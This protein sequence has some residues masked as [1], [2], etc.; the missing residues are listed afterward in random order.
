AAPNLPP[1][2][3]GTDTTAPKPET[4]GKTDF[5]KQTQLYGYLCEITGI[6]G[7]KVLSKEDRRNFPMSSWH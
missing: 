4:P 6:D 7:T 3:E 5:E 1:L 2:P